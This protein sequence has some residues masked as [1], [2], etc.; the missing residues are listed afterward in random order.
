MAVPNLEPVVD[1][2][3]YMDISLNPGPDV[4]NE[5]SLRNSSSLRQRTPSYIQSQGEGEQITSRF[6]KSVILETC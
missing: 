3:I 6:C 4:E 1:I 2:T 5:S